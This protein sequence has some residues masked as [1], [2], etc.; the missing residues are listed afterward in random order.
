[1]GYCLLIMLA[2]MGLHYV[3]FRCI[4][5][6]PWEWWA[7]GK[8]GDEALCGQP[9]IRTTPVACT[10]VSLQLRI[11]QSRSLEHLLTY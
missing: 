10:L 8:R 5:G 3:A 9:A 7:E 4:S 11:A 6:F 1:M 2:G